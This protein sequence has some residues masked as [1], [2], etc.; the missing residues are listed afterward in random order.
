MTSY[1]DDPPPAA[2][3]VEM[4]ND[5][6]IYRKASRALRNSKHNRNDED[7][8]SDIDDNDIGHISDAN[9][10]NNNPSSAEYNNHMSSHSLQRIAS[11]RDEWNLDERSANPAE[12]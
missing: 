7:A 6:V 12:G 9:H 10:Y 5:S 1:G 4:G 8:G 2:Y 3:G 11:A